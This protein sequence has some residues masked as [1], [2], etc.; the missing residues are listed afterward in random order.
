MTDASIPLLLSIMFVLLFLSAFFSGSETGMMSINRF[1]L[2]HLSKKS[3]AAKRVQTMLKRP[4]RLLGVILLGN[5]FVNIMA[6]AIASIVAIRIWGDVGV[7]IAS[8]LLTIIV[9]IF[10]EVTPKTLAALYPEK[11]AFPA[12][13]VL[14]VL[15]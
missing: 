8:I 3:R 2:K 12:S 4:D 7:L 13:N 5:N 14:K 15:F 1:R 11:F 9:L 10:A 6:S